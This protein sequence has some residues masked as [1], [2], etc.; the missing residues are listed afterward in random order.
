MTCDY[1][2]D[3]VV[4]VSNTQVMDKSKLAARITLTEKSI[5]F[6]L[7]MFQTHVF[8]VGL[9]FPEHGRAIVK[10]ISLMLINLLYSCINESARK[11]VSYDATVI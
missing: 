10:L 11:R 1:S 8:D 4:S 3:L 5:G 9:V 2:N 7:A 6:L